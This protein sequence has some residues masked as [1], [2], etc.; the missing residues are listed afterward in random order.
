MEFE[1][2]PKARIAFLGANPNVYTASGRFG[3]SY[4]IDQN[5]KG[6]RLLSYNFN[7]F[8]EGYYFSHLWRAKLAAREMES[9]QFK[10]SS[11]LCKIIN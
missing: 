10:E 2:Q 3:R 5:V 6:W 9:G 4:S 1:A 7:S 11:A 8:Y